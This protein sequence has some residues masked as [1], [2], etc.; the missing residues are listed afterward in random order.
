MRLLQRR[1]YGVRLIE[2]A[3]FACVV[4]L[5]LGVY[6]A[7]TF[8]G[9]E[10]SRIAMVERQIQEEQRKLKLLRAEVAHL[11][12]PDRIQQLSTAHLGMQAVDGTREARAETLPEIANPAEAKAAQA[13]AAV[14]IA[15]TPAA[16]PPAKG[17]VPTQDPAPQAP[18]SVPAEKPQ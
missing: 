8:A 9:R 18:T 11:E 12:Q 6:L 13:A 17:S 3:A 7:K 5:A 16:P 1:F 4:A 2:L 10:R 14:A 15:S